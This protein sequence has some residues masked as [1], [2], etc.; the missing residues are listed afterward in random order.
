MAK[1]LEEAPDRA[2]YLGNVMFRH[3]EELDDE[4]R[5][6]FESD[7]LSEHDKYGLNETVQRR[8]GIVEYSMSSMDVI[9]SEAFVEA[10]RLR[11]KMD[12]IQGGEFAAGDLSWGFIRALAGG[13]ITGGLFA[14][15]PMNIIGIVTGIAVIGGVYASGEEC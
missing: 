8:G 12:T 6:V 4:Y 7:L 2:R 9:L 13:C 10:R 15:P 3:P 11:V 14:P 5:R 1:L